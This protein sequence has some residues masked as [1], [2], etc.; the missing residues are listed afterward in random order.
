MWFAWII[1]FLIGF[2]MLIEGKNAVR[3]V[4]AEVSFQTID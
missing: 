2:D 4:G 1:W 3:A